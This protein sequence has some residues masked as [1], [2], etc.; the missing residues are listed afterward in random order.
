MPPMPGLTFI[1][2]QGSPAPPALAVPVIPALLVLFCS[3]FSSRHIV[4][5]ADSLRRAQGCSGYPSTL[6]CSPQDTRP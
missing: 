3:E 4:I 5:L 1:S 2:I 6:V